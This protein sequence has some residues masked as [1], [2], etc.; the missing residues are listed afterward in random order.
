[1]R[2]HRD[3]R[4][5]ERCFG[6]LEGQTIGDRESW[7][8]AN[9][10]LDPPGAEPIPLLEARILEALGWLAA[11]LPERRSIAVVTHGGAILTALRLLSDGRLP[12]MPGHRTID[13]E[14]ILNASI[15]HLAF[16]RVSNAARWHVVR[17][18]DVD[19][20]DESR[21]SSEDAG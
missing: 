18:N 4:W 10:T 16:D 1:L 7:R 17:V 2:A 5:R 21:I 13:V 12:T 11:N 8:A 14:P 9:G 20:L 19:H 3:A 6:E 15:L